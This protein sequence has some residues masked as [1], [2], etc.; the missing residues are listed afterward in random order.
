MGGLAEKQCIIVA[1]GLL[2]M[3]NFSLHLRRMC[4]S[5]LHYWPDEHVSG[6]SERE[7]SLSSLTFTLPPQ[8]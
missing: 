4:A 6:V 5:R 7:T 1:A 2:R 3:I 8:L